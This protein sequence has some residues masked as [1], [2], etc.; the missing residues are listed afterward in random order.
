MAIVKDILIEIAT[1]EEP[2]EFIPVYCGKDASLTITADVLKICDTVN[3]KWNKIL[4]VGLSGSMTTSG[5]IRIDSDQGFPDLFT[6][7]IAFTEIRVRY[8]MTDKDLNTKNFIANAY[9]TNLGAS[10]TV[11]SIGEQ[12]VE[13]TLSGIIEM[14]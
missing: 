12:S 10:F 8:A 6:T 2:D 7:M 13:L 9:I 3:G 14:E 1:L 4:P 5:L 11:F